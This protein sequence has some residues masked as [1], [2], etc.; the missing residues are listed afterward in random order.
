[1]K[2]IVGDGSSPDESGKGPY[3][4]AYQSHIQAGMLH[5]FRY[6]GEYSFFR[7]FFPFLPFL[8]LSMRSD[9]KWGLRKPD[10]IGFCV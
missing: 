4:G 10:E 1:M 2:E 8:G 9:V 3:S 5:Q 6:S 7:S